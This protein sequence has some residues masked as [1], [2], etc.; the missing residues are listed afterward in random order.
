MK[1]YLGEDLSRDVVM[2]FAIPGLNSMTLTSRS[3]KRTARNV[4][5]TTTNKLVIVMKENQ[6][7]VKRDNLFKRGDFAY[8]RLVRSDLNLKEGDQYKWSYDLESPTD[9]LMVEDIED[10]FSEM[11]YTQG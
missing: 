5:Q 2:A 9:S 11:D 1:T 3:T 6:L 7:W 8:T 4:T 10:D